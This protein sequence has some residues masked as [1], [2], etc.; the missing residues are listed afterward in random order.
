MDTYIE[1]RKR[2]KESLLPYLKQIPLYNIYQTEIISDS[3]LSRTK[4]IL[5][6]FSSFRDLAPKHL[7]LNEKLIE[8]YAVCTDMRLLLPS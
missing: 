7:E 2:I 5:L 3:I 4:I 8:L 6:Y 1:G